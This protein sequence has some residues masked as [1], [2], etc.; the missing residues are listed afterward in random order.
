VSTP[1]VTPLRRAPRRPDGRISL[2][3]V[4]DTLRRVAPVQVL[5]TVPG[6]PHAGRWSYVAV[7]V[8]ALH[9]DGHRST[10]ALDG[11]APEDLGADPFAAID[12][13]CQRFGWG[14]DA[15]RDPDLAPF[16]GGLVGALG[17]DLGRR[18]EVLPE[19]A[20]RDRTV[21]DVDLAVTRQLVAVDHDTER[22]WLV[23]TDLDGIE[24]EPV[25]VA[26]LLDRP[27]PVAGEVTR[28]GQLVRTTLPRAAYLTAVEAALDRIAAGDAFQVNLTQ[29]LTAS[30]DGDVHDLYRALRRQSRAAFGAVVSSRHGAGIA[31]ISPET[32][33][34]AEGRQ[35]RTRPIKGT[36]PRGVAAELD[37][38]LADDLATSAKD[39]AENV[40]VVDM[41]RNDLGRVCEVGS[42]RVPR[43]LELE[44]HP[45]VWHL[46]STVEGT[47]RAST[48][49]GELLRAA[50]PCGS[51][52][53]TPK[54][55]AMAIIDEL[56]PVRRGVY[57]GAVGFLG[58]GTMSTSVA[59]R[60]ASL[61]RDGTVD[62]GAGGGIVADSEPDAEHAESIDK[63]AAF[64]R[65][66]NATDVVPVG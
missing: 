35:V 25:P 5:E 34:H 63:A 47:L 19:R 6:T 54:V 20:V 14:P 4:V 41:E 52:T 16:T 43:L 17:Y 65:A 23:E 38:A 28:A 46:V 30:W 11:R 13:V 66:V 3:T 62:Y 1:R 55:R 49:F 33:L 27:A 31:S 53:G 57:C 32:F 22:A 56:E 39:R 51:V 50:F 40:M 26:D 8:G 60:T 29:R 10:L 24:T 59:I 48:G 42:V 12:R 7:V 61:S 64:L 15:P 58:A 37:A 45:T 9:D 44:A 36:R 2:D 18:I 21:A